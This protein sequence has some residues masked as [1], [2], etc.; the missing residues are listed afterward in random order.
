MKRFQHEIELLCPT[1]K[2]WA[3]LKSVGNRIEVIAEKCGVITIKTKY[4]DE[5]FVKTIWVDDENDG[6]SQNA[7][8]EVGNFL[9]R[10]KI[11][12]NIR[13]ILEILPRKKIKY[14][15]KLSKPTEKSWDLL[16][17]LDPHI[18]KHAKELNVIRENVEYDDHSKTLTLV[19]SYPDDLS[20]TK[21]ENNVTLCLKS[22]GLERKI[23]EA[24]AIE[25]YRSNYITDLPLFN[26]NK[27]IDQAEV[28][29]ENLVKI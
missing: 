27:L 12:I 4:D 2:K 13:S 3:K 5:L 9:G 15:V 21:M 20:R 17:S 10:N 26:A 1:K 7:Y 19:A 24:F 11:N 6:E 8:L 14:K 29:L 28:L 25:D 18:T 22:F 23:V 16:K